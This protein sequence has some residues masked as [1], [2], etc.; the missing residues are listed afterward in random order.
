[1]GYVFPPLTNL[2]QDICDHSELLLM[3]GA[4]TETTCWAYTSGLSSLMC[5]FWSEL[6]IKQSISRR[7]QLRRPRACE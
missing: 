7:P 1:M 6:G 4:D 5:I 2:V 3:W